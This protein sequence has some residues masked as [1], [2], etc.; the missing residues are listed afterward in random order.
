MLHRYTLMVAVLSA[1]TVSR[2]LAAQGRS[3]EDARVIDGYRLTMPVLRKVLPALSAPG[4]QNC[5]RDGSRDPH[6]MS[7]AD[8]VRMLERCAP[9]VDALKRAGV[10]TRDGV[11]VFASLLRTAK[12]VALHSGNANGIAAGVLRDNALL[13]ERNDPEIRRLTK[14]GGPS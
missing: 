5:P 14:T 11:I 13:V 6:T 4:A 8:M 3:A 12:E 1:L 10:P 9:V 7:I 2:V